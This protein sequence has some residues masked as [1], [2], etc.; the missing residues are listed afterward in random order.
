MEVILTRIVNRSEDGL[1]TTST[2][3]SPSLATTNRRSPCYAATPWGHSTG[4]FNFEQ[5]NSYEMPSLKSELG[6][7]LESHFGIPKETSDRR[8]GYGLSI[9]SVRQSGRIQCRDDHPFLRPQESGQPRRLGILEA[10]GL[11]GLWSLSIYRL[12]TRTGFAYSSHRNS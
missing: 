6:G 1:L 4:V 9:M 5:T 7:H 2:E 11:F 8:V 10:T 3:F 12:G